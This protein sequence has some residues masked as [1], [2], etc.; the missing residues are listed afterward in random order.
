MLRRR[1][2]TPSTCSA[3]T[4]TW[5]PPSTATR[6]STTSSRAPSPSWRWSARPSPDV[7]GPAGGVLGRGPA[8]AG[9]AQV[10]VL[11]PRPRRLPG[12]PPGRAGPGPPRLGR[13]AS[14]RG[15]TGIAALHPAIPLTA[16]ILLRSFLE[17]YSVV[18]L[19]LAAASGPA[20][21]TD[22]D[23]LPRRTVPASAAS[24]SCSSG[25]SSPESVSRPL[26]AHRAAAGREP[27][28]SPR[29]ATTW[30]PGGPT[31]PGSCATSSAS[32]TASRPWP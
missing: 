8:A 19:A 11:L 26:F 30:P 18:A 25:S 16:H 28:A 29:T 32:S 3:P 7:D 9:P 23:G 21:V 15:P 6:S 20:P 24:A 13:S 22:A 1:A 14:P 5:P 2:R 12:R 31:S 17:A 27:R 4:S 10:R